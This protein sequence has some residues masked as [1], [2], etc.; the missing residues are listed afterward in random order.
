[1][2]INATDYTLASWVVNFDG[3]NIYRGCFV[4][5]GRGG[6]PEA[7][8]FPPDYPTTANCWLLHT[9]Q[10]MYWGRGMWPRPT[11]SVPFISPKTAQASRAIRSTVP[12]KSLTSTGEIMFGITCENSTVP[13]EMVCQLTATSGGH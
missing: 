1:M 3:L 9:P 4:R 11:A 12:A 2:L 8:P 6:R 13:S 7:L 5:A 10:A